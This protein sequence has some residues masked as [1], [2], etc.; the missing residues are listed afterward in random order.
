[1]A[2]R[3]TKTNWAIQ[4]DNVARVEEKAFLSNFGELQK[5]G[6]HT[7]NEENII[8]H[9]VVSISYFEHS[10]GEGSSFTIRKYM[11]VCFLILFTFIIFPTF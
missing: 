4:A 6:L 2:Q 11:A 9:A 3:S 8:H 10:E 7:P 5:T 1:M